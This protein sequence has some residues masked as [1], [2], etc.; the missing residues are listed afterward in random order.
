MFRA[1]SVFLLT[2]TLIQSS[3]LA[4]ET[5]NELSGIVQSNLR[6]SSDTHT[7][8]PLPTDVIGTTETNK[9]VSLTEVLA[10]INE[11]KGREDPSH[12][13]NIQTSR[14]SGSNFTTYAFSCRVPG[15]EIVTSEVFISNENSKPEV[16][17]YQEMRFEE[18][19]INRDQMLKT[20]MLGQTETFHADATVS[21]GIRTLITLAKVGVPVALSFKTAKILSP[22]R[23][24]WQ[25]HFIA[26]AIISGATVLTAEGIIRTMN[27]RRGW[28]LSNTKISLLSS[29]AGLLSSITA[30]AAK[31]LI[32]DKTLG[33]GHPEFKDALY[34]AAGGA[35]VSFTVAIPLEKIFGHRKPNFAN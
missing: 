15:S 26:G 4:N 13:E 19:P 31:E 8:T 3:A 20:M 27:N 29:F 33:R 2:S 6:N 5:L 12:P 10:R 14:E 23:K 1:L 7:I 11:C 34:T 22:L 18:S 25:K 16:V 17:S 35:M 32:W 21:P 28:G 9:Q 24:D 30:G